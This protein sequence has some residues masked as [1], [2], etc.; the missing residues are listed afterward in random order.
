MTTVAIDTNV[1]VYAFRSDVAEHAL[2]TNALAAHLRRGD[3]LLVLPIV[4]IE[5][6]RVVTHPRLANPSAPLRVARA[7]LDDLL[8]VSGVRWG[9]SVRRAA[10]LD[11]V[12]DA[13]EPV[14]NQ[15]YDT[16][17]VASAIDAG[18]TAIL[19]NDARFPRVT[20]FDVRGIDAQ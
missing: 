8:V 20:G 18:A 11:R 14:G 16:E 6:L 7:F 2:A 19:T 4:A 9:G 10:V 17:V 13:I 1:L 5:F 15:L 3:T 12:L